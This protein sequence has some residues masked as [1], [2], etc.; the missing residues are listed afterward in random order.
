MYT[1]LVADLKKEGIR[2]LEKEGNLWKESSTKKAKD[3]TRQAITDRKPEHSSSAAPKSPSSDKPVSSKDE[4]SV[5]SDA[6]AKARSTAPSEEHDLE[7][8]V[9]Q[10]S[11]SLPSFDEYNNT[12]SHPNL[13]DGSIDPPLTPV[14]DAMPTP[15]AV[16][17]ESSTYVMSST[18]ES[19]APLPTTLVEPC[20]RS[21]TP[22]RKVDATPADDSSFAK[23]LFDHYDDDLDKNNFDLQKFDR[24]I[25]DRYKKNCPPLPTLSSNKGED[26]QMG[27]MLG[28]DESPPP[29]FDPLFVLSHTTDND[30]NEALQDMVDDDMSLYAQI[31]GELN[32]HKHRIA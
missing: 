4:A 24:L 8:N 13:G 32:D 30:D 26:D 23:D 14:A 16:T 1:G 15:T 22:V 20:G 7:Q 19:L 5:S 29:T 11:T 31:L 9:S 21:N 6:Q 28:D 17:P 3:K 12:Y 2:F 10:G 27:L 18:S 25:D